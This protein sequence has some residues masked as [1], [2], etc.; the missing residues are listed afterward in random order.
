MK[1]DNGWIG[2]LFILSMFVVT[3]V[4]SNLLNALAIS[5]THKILD[6]AEIT[7]LSMKI[8]RLND[9]EKKISK[10]YSKFFETF[11][12]F[13]IFHKIY[14]EIIFFHGER[15]PQYVVNLMDNTIRL[16]SE[17]KNKLEKTEKIKLDKNIVEK[18][19]QVIEQTIQV[20]E[21]ITKMQEMDKMLQK[22]AKHLKI[23]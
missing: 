17:E 20:E 4:L 7:D 12:N 8:E 10:D 16:G 1:I 23:S 22:I 19:R 6:D 9:I 3:I 18:F 13:K 21:N 15:T 2:L 14:K 11:K 5:D